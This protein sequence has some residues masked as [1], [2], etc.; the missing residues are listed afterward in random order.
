MLN[1][2]LIVACL[3]SG[4]LHGQRIAVSRT[5]M[6][7]SAVSVNS[8]VAVTYHLGRQLSDLKADTVNG[9][10]YISAAGSKG[11]VAAISSKTDSV[12]WVREGQEGKMFLSRGALIA[13][14]SDASTRFDKSNGSPLQQIPSQVLFMPSSDEFVYYSNIAEGR[15]KCQKINDGAVSWEANVPATGNWCDVKKVS[16]SLWVVAA[17]GIHGIHPRKGLVWSIPQSLSEN[18][19]TQ[20]LRTGSFNKTRLDATSQFRETG[21]AN[22]VTQL[23]S[24]ILTDGK[25]IWFAGR[26]KLVCC[27]MSGHVQWNYP[28]GGRPVSRMFLYNT[29]NGMYLLNTAVAHHNGRAVGW[30][31]PFLVRVDPAT[32]Q[33]TGNWDSELLDGLTD[34]LPMG[35]TL[36]LATR[37]AIFETDIGP[38]LKTVS[39]M[40]PSYGQLVELISGTEHHAMKEGYFVP[41][42]IIDKAIYY[43]S[44]NNKIYALE[45]NNVKF[46][47][48]SSAVYKFAARAADKVLLSNA[49]RTLVT[50]ANF[51]LLCALK[52]SGQPFVTGGKVYLAQGDKIHSILLKELK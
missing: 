14:T 46:E 17:S 38:N 8:I 31:S 34:F 41:L 25:L 29:P 50:D 2:L 15:L 32:G 6:G 28:L 48:N 12:S 24:N 43:R 30:G 22:Q 52:G 7:S 36:R 44:D 27:D 11:I 37:E 10:L 26:E 3:A 40:D 16:D 9:S 23:S 49:D 1:R 4:T 33:E 51:E 45:R 47:Y 20:P 13:T 42:V 21:G 39:L 18:P 35:G 19:G 5:P